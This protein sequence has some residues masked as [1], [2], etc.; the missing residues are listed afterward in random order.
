L[1]HL[2]PDDRPREKL[3]RHG[4][5]AVGDNELVALVLGNGCRG[6]DAL[7]AANDLLQTCGGLHGLARATC[8]ELAQL[9][10][11]GPAKAA[12][13]V[14][15]VELG[16]R[17]LMRV[18]AERVPLRTP[19]D[20]ARYLLPVFGARGTEQFGIVLLDS[21]YR[22]LRTSIVAVGTLNTAIVEPRDVFRAAMLG[23]AAALV[24]FHN[25]PSGDPT[26]SAEDMLL[27]H[28]LV[29]A[30]RLIGIDVVDH[31]VLGDARY[32][33]FKETGRL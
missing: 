24:I 17:S 2:S 1:K 16:R 19:G 12:R 21:R 26:P 6:L 3:L 14:G 4:P 15:A 29:E 32:C 11:V 8:G 30:G 7:A 33:S 27:T 22:A 5:A 10:G 25:H 13:L 28:R 31:I 9:A 20:A 23:G 18:P